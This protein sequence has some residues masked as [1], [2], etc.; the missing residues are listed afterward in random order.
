MARTMKDS[1]I[2]WIGEIPKEWEVV[3]HKYVM[4]KEKEIC[5]KYNGEDIISLTMNGV[6]V[7]DLVNPTGKMPATF[8][9]YQRVCAGNLLMCLFDIDVTPRCIGYIK[10]NGLTSPAYSQFV[11]DNGNYPQY[12]DYLLRMIDDGKHFLHLSKNLRS[13]LTEENFG[14]IKT[15]VPS[16]EEQKK[17][18]DFLDIKVVEIDSIIKQTKEAIEEYKKYK[19][20]VILEIVTKGLNHSVPMVKVELDFAN[21]I[22][23]HWSR[24]KVS[25][26]YSM[27]SGKNIIAENFV[28]DGTFKVYG[29][30][31][32]RGYYNEYN[33]DGE[34]LLVGRQGALCG[35]IH[36][37]NE[38]IWAT[39]HAL[40]CDENTEFTY[41]KY[42]FY[43]FTAMN[44][45]Q[46]SR[47]AAQPGISSGQIGLLYTCMPPVEEQIEIAEY[48]DE[49]CAEI[50]TLIEKKEAFVEELESY[51]Q[52]LIYEYVTGKKEV[53]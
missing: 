26:L 25:R 24:I 18:A 30:N 19:K 14:A 10:N 4:H 40:V 41:N 48:L 23:K 31:G 42:Y 1:G 9:G 20:A 21:E 38:K 47:S 3:P 11:V 7:R 17:I 39:D 12:Y 34:H 32:F 8:D 33:T 46:Y 6:I 2:L 27:H 15:I 37:V 43:C 52:S 45:N 5:E 53:L 35:N 13:S 36:L 29:G 16:V 51:K 28:D 49:K 22:P 44:F 50:D